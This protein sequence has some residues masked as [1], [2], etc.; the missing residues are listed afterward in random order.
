LPEEPVEFSVTD[1]QIRVMR[2]ESSFGAG[3]PGILSALRAEQPGAPPLSA[4]PTG[5]DRVALIKDIPM[6]DP[7]SIE[8]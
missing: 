1:E 6:R 3:L 2:L 7:H 4:P 5:P 8:G